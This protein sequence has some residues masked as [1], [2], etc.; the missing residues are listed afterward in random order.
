MKM[1]IWVARYYPKLNKWIGPL[2]CDRDLDFEMYFA[3]RKGILFDRIISYGPGEVLGDAYI[4]FSSFNKQE[5][6][7]WMNEGFVP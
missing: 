4:E 3:R 7:E 6:Q 1:Y 5:V 2:E